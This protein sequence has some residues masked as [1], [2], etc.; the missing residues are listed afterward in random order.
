[1]R[2]GG[3]APPIPCLLAHLL[4]ITSASQHCVADKT[5]GKSYLSANLARMKSVCHQIGV[6]HPINNC[7]KLRTRYPSKTRVLNPFTL[8]H[9][10]IAAIL[11]FVKT[12]FHCFQKY[13]TGKIVHNFS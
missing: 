6:V 5:Q 11:L 12:D 3:S 1:M 2:A 8:K 10:H 7:L 9:K 4:D 13:I